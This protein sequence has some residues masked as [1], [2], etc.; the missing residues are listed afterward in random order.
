MNLELIVSNLHSGFMVAR[1]CFF[2]IGTQGKGIL[3]RKI[4]NTGRYNYSA[5]GSRQV[6]IYWLGPMS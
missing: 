6:P 3:F 2:P 1:V 5:L 4:Q